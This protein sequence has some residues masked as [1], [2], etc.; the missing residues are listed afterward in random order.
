[1]FS[2]HPLLRCLALYRFMPGRFALTAL[3]FMVANLSLAWQQWLI[4]RAVHDVERGVAVVRHN[5]GALDFS[6]ARNWLVVLLGIA[7]ARGA[8]QYITGML[9]LMIGQELL[10]LLRDRILVQVQRL[11]L[12]YHWRHG[13]GELVTRTTRDADKVRDALIN[14][15]RQVFETGL[16]ALAAIGMLF[17][18]QPLLGLIPLGLTAAGLSLFVFQTSGLVRLDRAVGAAYDAV[19]QDLSEAVH[20]V[21]VIKAFAL[22][23]GRIAGFN[24]QIDHFTRHA[25]AALAFAVSRVP[26]PQIVVALSQVWILVY[27][28]ELIGAGRLNVGELVAALLMANTLVFRVEGVGRVMQIFAD[29]RSSAARIW[30]LLDAEPAIVGG[31]ETLPEGALG[32]RFEHVRVASPGGN[33]I[34]KDCSFQVNP[35][36]IVALVGTT[37]CG[38]STVAALLPHL[39]AADEGEIAIGSDERG[40][41]DIRGVSPDELRHRVHVV[42]QDSFLFSDTLAANLRVADLNASDTELLAA[43]ERAAAGELIER[44]PEGLQTPLGDR[45]V[46]LSGGQRQRICLARALLA[47]ASILGLDDATSALDAATERTVLRNLREFKNT[48]GGRTVTVLIVSSKLSTILM[49]DRVLLLADG[50]IAAQGTHRQ[51][52]RDCAAYC[53]LLGI[54][55]DG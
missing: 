40:W 22:E 42:T 53:E 13:V 10:T 5:D 39:L 3:L 43:L 47:K 54:E 35:G 16:V 49:A 33:P 29:A 25:N 37:G 1:M 31:A 48:A 21:R 11:D 7:L 30:E 45:G 23:P 9:S 20:G 28:V 6:V 12:I 18:Y 17:W 55:A 15:W 4:G 32:V 24:Q 14:L 26:L 19:S 38:K 44:L 51:L 36:E 41:A 2:R 46:T 52:V 27:G 34:L 8:V 50:R